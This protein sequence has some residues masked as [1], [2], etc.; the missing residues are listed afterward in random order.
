MT[1]FVQAYQRALFQPVVPVI[2]G[3]MSIFG[4][5]AGLFGTLQSISLGMR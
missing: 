3:V 5:V 4:I 2:W 1:S